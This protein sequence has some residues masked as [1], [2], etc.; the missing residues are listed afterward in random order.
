MYK[1]FIMYLVCIIYVVFIYSWSF[2]FVHSDLKYPFIK[3]PI[4]IEYKQTLLQVDISLSICRNSRSQVFHKIVVL[5]FSQNS[6][7]NTFAGV[8]KVAI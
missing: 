8:S 2:H 1:L 6:K 4:N 3:F 5:K 7:K